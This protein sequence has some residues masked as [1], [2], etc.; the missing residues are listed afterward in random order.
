MDDSPDAGI[1]QTCEEVRTALPA[2]AGET[3]LDPAV[4]V[5][6]TAKL[7]ARRHVGLGRAAG[8]MDHPANRLHADRR[9]QSAA[10]SR[11]GGPRD[12]FADGGRPRPARPVPARP[13]P[14]RSRP[15]FPKSGALG[16]N[17]QSGNQSAD[18]S[19]TFLDDFRRY[20]GYDARPYLAAFWAGGRQPAVTP[21]PAPLPQNVGRLRGRRYYGPLSAL[22]HQPVVESVRGGGHPQIPPSVPGPPEE[23]RLLRRADGE[24]WQDGCWTEHGQNKNGKRPPPPVNL[25]GKRIAA[26]EAFTLNRD[27]H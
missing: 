15:A 26:A 17:R 8:P 4:I 18:W 27:P 24:F 21:L 12:G 10:D 2:V 5:D 23:L 11:R 3:P 25:Y 20:R 6:L 14:G 1:R 16:A 7:V 22:A 9:S 19:P 13:A